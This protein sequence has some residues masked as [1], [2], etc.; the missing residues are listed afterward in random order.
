MTSIT[1]RWRDRRRHLRDLR[2]VGRA[3]DAAPTPSMRDE[4]IAVAQRQNLFPYR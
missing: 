3:I 4:L 1:R 2:E